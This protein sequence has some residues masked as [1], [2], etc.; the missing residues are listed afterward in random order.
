MQTAQRLEDREAA[1]DR[2]LGLGRPRGRGG[3]AVHVAVRVAVPVGVRGTSRLLLLRRRHDALAARLGECN[4]E[5]D[6]LRDE[7]HEREERGRGV[8]IELRAPAVHR[9]R[10]GAGGEVR[11]DGWADAEAYR[12]SDADVRERL[13]AGGRR[14]YVG[15]DGTSVLRG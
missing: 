10:Q 13:R 1:L 11:A 8:D 9:L 6:G 7:Q 14:R 3:L 4:G 2:A 15:E 5:E 12:E